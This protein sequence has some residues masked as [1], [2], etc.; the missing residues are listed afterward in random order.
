MPRRK[1][2]RKA[3][4]RWIKTARL[5]AGLTQE[6]LASRTGISI[7]S[8]SR[9]ETD[10]A[11]P[12]FSDICTVAIAL[13]SPLLYFATGRERH[14]DDTNAIVT[15]LRFWGLRDLLVAEPVLLGEVRPFEELFAAVLPGAVDPRVL[16]GLPALLLQNAFDPERLLR[17]ARASGFVRRAGWLSDIADEISRRL[18]PESIHPDAHG[19]LDR[20]TNTAWRE[21]P[22]ETPDYP[23]RLS[24]DS[25][26]ERVW[27]ASPPLTRR[28]KI[29]CD[30][31]L[32][33]F[34]S[35]ARSLLT[36]E[37]RERA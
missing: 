8:L 12:A 10:R 30:I 5:E 36:S 11:Q 4:G 35:R 9:F 6:Q 13:G 25:L 21:A 1:P 19:R 16:E 3:I 23:G 20:V 15:E 17:F 27:A 29:A 34:E 14:G 2:G 28:W 22:P 26:H 32:D 24:S 31:T 7:P 37:A 18:P 33:E